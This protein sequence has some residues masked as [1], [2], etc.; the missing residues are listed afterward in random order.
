MLTINAYASAW[1]NNPANYRR[2]GYALF[3]LLL[4]ACS[5]VL[6]YSVR[7]YKAARSNNACSMLPW[8]WLRH[9]IPGILLFFVFTSFGLTG[10]FDG[11]V[12][13]TTRS[14][15]KYMHPNH[16]GSVAMETAWLFHTGSVRPFSSSLSSGFF[17]A[18]FNSLSCATC[19]SLV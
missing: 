2:L 12:D 13:N 11:S 16:V 6:F 1:L 3:G 14:N 9:S 15:V 4:A 8:P 10:C 17:A 19:F 7:R 18:G 5:F